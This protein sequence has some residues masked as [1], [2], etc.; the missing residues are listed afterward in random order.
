MRRLARYAV[1]L[2][3]AASLAL[4]VATVALWVRDAGYSEYW[5]AAYWRPPAA[6]RADEWQFWFASTDGRLCLAVGR[7]AGGGTPGTE[8]ARCLA[9][10]APYGRTFLHD[11]RPRGPGTPGDTFHAVHLKLTDDGRDR[12]VWELYFTHWSAALATA[13]APA[14]AA[15]L[16]LARRRHHRRDPDACR[17]CGYDLRA[18]PIRCPE[19]GTPAGAP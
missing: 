16:H 19:C 12:D 18:T 4:F 13:I 3:T 1:R 17:A 14:T 10:R 9:D 2:L 5:T 8:T 15:A 6:G 11:R 7:W